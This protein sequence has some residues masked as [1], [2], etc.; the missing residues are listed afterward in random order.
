M[1]GS[2]TEMAVSMKNNNRHIL[3]ADIVYSSRLLI[4][5]LWA[6][7]EY[8]AMMKKRTEKRSNEKPMGVGYTY[9]TRTH[10]YIHTHTN[11]HTHTIYQ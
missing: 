6:L 9:I 3:E 8:A 11:T 10:T 5:Q 1:N 2:G 7:Q 4:C